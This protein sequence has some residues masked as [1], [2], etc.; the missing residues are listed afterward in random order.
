MNKRTWTSL[1]SVRRWS[2]AA[3]L[4]GAT[5]VG[6]GCALIPTWNDVHT[7]TTTVKDHV[8]G[9]AAQR[10]TQQDVRRGAAARAS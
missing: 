8:T 10:Q 7:A 1:G 3:L 5:L 2:A 4:S 9:K 6:S